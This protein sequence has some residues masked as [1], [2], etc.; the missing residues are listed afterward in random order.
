M[1]SL[2]RDL[3]TARAHDVQ[4]S[5][6]RA[7]EEGSPRDGADD[8]AA[9]ESLAGRAGAE[10]EFVL[11]DGEGDEAGEPEEGGEGVEEEDGVLVEVFAGGLVLVGLGEAGVEEEVGEGE[12][13]EA[14]GEDQEGHFVGGGG[15]A[16]VG[17]VPLCD[18]LVL[19]VS[20]VGSEGIGWGAYHSR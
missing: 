9:D 8:D 3:A 16:G 4:Q 12:E 18:C 15:R 7:G 14:G 20:G 6:A 2:S 13:G 10:G 17:E 19:V 1:G 11:E 5:Q